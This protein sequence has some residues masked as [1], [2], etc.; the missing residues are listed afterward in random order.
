MRRHRGTRRIGTRRKGR[1][2]DIVL[3]P[4]TTPSKAIMTIMG[5][6]K[7]L[8]SPVGIAVE[9]WASKLGHQRH[10][11]LSQISLPEAVTA[12][13]EVPPTPFAVV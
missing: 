11:C 12:P 10:L 8:P 13:L 9:R 1:A 7:L 2:P 6:L 3:R 5:A 4:P